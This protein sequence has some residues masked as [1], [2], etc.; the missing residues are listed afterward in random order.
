MTEATLQR[1]IQKA[2][3]ERGGKT[4]KYHG[5]PYSVA[6]TPDLIGVLNGRSFAI[7]VKLIGKVA[8]LKQEHELQEWA[9][10]G[11]ASGIAHSVHEA[12]DIIAAAG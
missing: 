4:I 12:L 3:R 11:W 2:I 8:T 5:G 1:N 10:Q 9:A 6:G 7:E